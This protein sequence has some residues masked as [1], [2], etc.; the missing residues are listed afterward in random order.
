MK[1]N[2]IEGNREHIPTLEEVISV[3]REILKGK[4]FKLTR[5]LE[6]SKGLYVL[7]IKTKGEKDGEVDEY[8]Y[9]R[10]GKYKEGESSMTEIYM[11]KYYNSIAITGESA[12]RYID[13]KWKIL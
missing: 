11:A 10:K 7:E 9:M 12:A 2:P 6:D 3:F 4:D 8:S 1:Q 5:K 13:E